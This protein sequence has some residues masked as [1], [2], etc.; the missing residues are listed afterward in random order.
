VCWAVKLAE[1]SWA[2]TWS[3]TRG[4]VYLGGEV[5]AVQQSGVYWMHQDPVAKSKRVTNGSGT[6]VSTIELDPWGG[7]TNRS[8]SE[9][10]Q[11]RKFTT[12]EQ[13]SIGSHDAMNRRYNRWWARFEQPDPYGGS[14]NL[15]DPQ[16]FNRYNYVQND[17]VNFVDPT[18]LVDTGN[19]CSAQYSFTEC[20]GRGGIHGG[21]FG[22]N[23]AEYRREYGSL[24]PHIVEGMREYNERVGNARGGNGFLTN[25]EVIRDLNFD[26]HYGYN[27]DGSVWTDF[28][29]DITIGERFNAFGEVVANCFPRLTE[30]HIQRALRW[31]NPGDLQGLDIVRVSDESEDDPES[32]D[33]PA[34]LKG[35][36][37]SGRYLRHTATR[38]AQVVLYANYVYLGVPKLLR[39]SPMV[40]WNL[41]RILAHEVGHHV[42]S[43]RGYVYQPSEKYKPW[44]GVRDPFEETMADAYAADVMNR[45]IRRWRYKRG[46]FLARMLS[47]LLYRAGIQEYWDGNYQ[48]AASL[49]FRAYA[50]NPENEDAGQCYRHAMEKLKT[51][52]PSP[53]SPSEREWLL[54][55]YDPT[56][57]HTATAGRSK[58]YTTRNKNPVRVRSRKRAKTQD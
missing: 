46:R 7:E 45:M 36:P 51:Q 8:S 24:P 37:Y 1:I 14:Y 22:G 58:Q 15:T 39:R 44:D 25:E 49:E 43:T 55:K 11:P 47:T 6:V 31:I 26:I 5:L 54:H 57:L 28:N 13:D 29:I 23:Y 32:A 12:Y 50:L 19:F 27:P 18:G 2:G 21:Y 34:Y 48:S 16:S 41:A 17:P 30:W 10:F 9:A 56:P 53:L 40:T 52:S 35:F 20:G 3:W 33:L 38:P 4:Y 42:I